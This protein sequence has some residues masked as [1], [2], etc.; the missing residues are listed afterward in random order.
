MQ[1]GQPEAFGVFDHHQR[2]IRHIDADF[3]DGRRDQ[4]IDRPRCELLHHRGFFGAGQLSVKQADAQL[5]QHA[6]NALVR[7]GSCRCLDRGA[8]LDQRAHPVGL[9]SGRDVATDPR[10][11]LVAATH[12]DQF[13]DDRPP[14]RRQL[15]DHRDVEIGEEAHCERARDRC[16]RQHQH[17]R[18]QRPIRSA[19]CE[20]LRDAEAMLLIDD[21]KAEPVVIH[22]VLDQRVGANRQL[23]GPA[24]HQLL[25]GALGCGAKPAGQPGRAHAE[26]RSHPAMW[27]KCCSASSSV[28]AIAAACQPDSTR[29]Q[30]RVRNHGLAAANI[31]LHQPLHWML[32]GEIGLDFAPDALLRPRQPEGQAGEQARR[33]SV[34][35]QR[36]RPMAL[37]RGPRLAQSDLLGNQFVKLQALPGRVCA[38]GER[39]RVRVR[40]RLMQPTQR[41]RKHR[42]VPFVAQH[43]M[44]HIGLLDRRQRARDPLAQPGLRDPGR[45]RINRR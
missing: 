19:Q 3:D 36:R 22:R 4:H 6:G 18:Q 8:L 34:G 10:Q 16:G 17:V 26:G 24:R 39:P 1:L 38:L 27:P 41:C 23:R 11:D 9:S 33:K 7:L 44:Q 31:A 43:R 15:V 40:W 25:R 5:R 32:A 37:P 12:R 30:R 20:S 13:G 29:A 28:G 35:V 14:A 2:R 21:R 42:K 45:Q